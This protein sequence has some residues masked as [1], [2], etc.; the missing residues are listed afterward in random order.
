MAWS[1][2]R[3]ILA[4]I[5]SRRARIVRPSPP[6][7]RP[8]GTLAEF[9]RLSRF[10]P[11]RYFERAIAPGSWSIPIALSPRRRATTRVVEEPQ[12]GFA[13]D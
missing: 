13:D 3:R 12:Q 10:S 6:P 7:P 2:A 4:D 1:P 8:A 9:D 11:N 5:D